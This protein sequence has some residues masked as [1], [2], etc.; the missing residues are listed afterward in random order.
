MIND[1]PIFPDRPVSSN[2]YD[3]DM[4]LLVT[5]IFPTIQ[6]EGPFSGVRC[7]FVRLAGCNLGGK[8]INGPGCSFCDT[9]F[10]F[11][12]GK[13]M[14]LEEVIDEIDRLH[15]GPLFAQERPLVVIT[16][17]E[18]M[19]QE[20][21]ADLLWYAKYQF[22][23]ESNGRRLV[24]G[25][26]TKYPYRPTLVVSPKI[27]E[28]ARVGTIDYPKLNHAVEDQL[29][30]LKFVVHA[31]P[32]NPYHNVPEWANKYPTYVSPMA[33]YKPGITSPNKA[34]ISMWDEGIFDK[35]ATRRNYEY[36][37]EL[38]MKR[39]FIL[40]LQSHLFISKE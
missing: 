6:G 1:N 28:L 8:G 12:N 40:S 33:M 29:D 15:P 9:D 34:V 3:K 18:P 39:G 2:D 23:I 14:K 7:V 10:R 22:Q 16:G 11:A 31:D 5:K 32:N 27:T 24:P 21:L 37:G 35:E 25:Y 17:G 4:G 30:Y 20:R 26:P 13:Y 36:A 38:A 19:L